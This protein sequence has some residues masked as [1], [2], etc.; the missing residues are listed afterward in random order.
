MADYYGH[1]I[2]K[3]A[4]DGMVTTVAGGGPIFGPPFGE[5]AWGSFRDGRSAEARFGF[6]HG[7]ALDGNGNLFIA[8]DYRRIRRISPSG[9]VSTHAGG[10]ALGYRDGHR[11]E[12]QFF[13]LLAI[14]VDADGNIYVIDNHFHSG[15]AIRK[16]DTTGVVSTLRRGT[17]SFRSGTLAS[18]V[19]LAVTGDGAIYVANTGRH[20]ILELTSRGILRAVAGTGEQG[21]ADGS[22]SEA[23]FNLPGAIGVADDGRLVVA[24]EGNNLIRTIAPTATSS[25]ARGQ[26]LAVAG[27]LPRLEDVKVTVF[28]SGSLLSRPSGMALDLEGNVIVADSGRHAIRRISPRGTVTTIAGGRGQGLRD[29][30]G[31]G[32][33]FSEPEGVAVHADGSIYVADSRNNRIRRIAP[34]GSVTT[35]AGAARPRPRRIGA[36]SAMA[37]PAK[38]DSAAR[39]HSHSTERETWSS[40][41]RRTAGYDC[42]RRTARSRPSRERRPSPLL[43]VTRETP[44]VRTG[45]GVGRS[46]TRRTGSPSPPTAASSSPRATPPSA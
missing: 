41:I 42:S 40:L 36:T 18:A 45:R 7:I 12:A 24:D 15:I 13:N 44:G 39:A 25:S 16:V 21:Y 23:M 22:R 32:A 14:D 4:P 11:G 43:T 19:G 5:G 17:A 10:G 27:Q 30:V 1:R 28:A 2:R 38:R 8:E 3:I 26:T 20:Q 46:S 9:D 6:P 33:Q 35:V 31:R 37:R 34:D 29:D